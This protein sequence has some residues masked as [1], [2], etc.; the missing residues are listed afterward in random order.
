M[1]GFHRDGMT[2]WH[3]ESLFTSDQ[4]KYQPDTRNKSFNNF[5]IRVQ[6]KYFKVPHV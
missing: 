4:D 5:L 3:S 1:L 2:L 6:L